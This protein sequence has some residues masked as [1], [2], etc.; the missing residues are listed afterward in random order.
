MK[1]YLNNLKKKLKLKGFTLIELLAVL[2]ILVIIMAITTPIILGVI[3]DAR[4]SADKTTMEQI[5][6]SA[7]LY[8]AGSFLDVEPTKFDGLTNLYENLDLSGEKP[9]E[10]L[11]Y[12]KENGDVY[13]EAEKD[14]ICYTKTY[15]SDIVIVSERD[16]CMENVYNDP[17]EYTITINNT[18]G[19]QL[20]SNVI[21]ATHGTKITLT[22]TADLNFHLSTITYNGNY[23]ENNEFIMPRENIIITP[24]WNKD[25]F[26]ITIVPSANGTLSVTNTEV[27]FGDTVNLVA[28]PDENYRL[29]KIYVDGN[30]LSGTS[31]VMPS[32]H[33]SITATFTKITYPITITNSAGGTISSNFVAA[34]YGDSI[35]VYNTPDSQYRLTG[36]YLN[37]V[38]ISGSSF[39]MPNSA[40]TITATWEKI[41]YAINV[42]NSLGGTLT[43]NKTNAS[44]N[45]AVTVTATPSAYYKLSGIYVN[46]VKISGNTFTMPANITSVTAIWEKITYA[47]NVTNS[48]GGTLNVNK[49]SASYNEVITVTAI[50]ISNYMLSGIYVNGIKISGNTFTMPANITSVTATWQR[51]NDSVITGGAMGGSFA[52]GFGSAYVVVNNAGYYVAN[53]GA[54]GIDVNSSSGYGN[55]YHISGQR[56]TIAKIDFSNVKYIEYTLNVTRS[57]SYQCS[58]DIA[59]KIG[60]NV[61]PGTLVSEGFHSESIKNFTITKKVD[62][63]SLGAVLNTPQTFGIYGKYSHHAPWANWYGGNIVINLTSL[64]LYYN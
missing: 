3:D 18:I 52:Q 21:T 51:N 6:D 17:T 40:A 50:P 39:V 41:T 10:A 14:G 48:L 22:P 13:F 64:T 30:V 36:I 33:V 5:V 49:T 19:G 24:I 28:T 27:A 58:S 20:V 61:I 2:V 8:Y 7:D 32:S 46:G 26:D 29:D 38:K 23:V 35:T 59:L 57:C 31:F 54:T 16:D 11:V 25:L 47:I 9:V 42:T 4:K 60:S 62:I 45:E 1:K 37:G 43:V 53:Y 15:E 56:D 44:Y 55:T 63:T 12:I 34:A